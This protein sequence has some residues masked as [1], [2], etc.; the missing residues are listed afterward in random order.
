MDQSYTDQGVFAPSDAFVDVRIRVRKALYLA[1][2][3][4][5]EA[6]KIWANF[7]PAAFL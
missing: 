4:P 2:L 7:I 1:S 3:A 5:E 6:V